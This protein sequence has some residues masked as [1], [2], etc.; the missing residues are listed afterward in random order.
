[1]STNPAYK[2]GPARGGAK[3][4]SERPSWPAPPS[5]KIA[6]GPSAWIGLA[7]MAANTVIALVDLFLL[8]GAIPR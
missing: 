7:L 4:M 5:R 6:A 3:A 2:P 1:M 8:A